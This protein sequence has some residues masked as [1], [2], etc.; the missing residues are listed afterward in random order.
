MRDVKT[1]DIGEVAKQ[2][3]LPTSALRFYEEKGLI[4]S[5]GRHGLRRLFDPNVLERLSLIALARYGG[6]SLKEIAAMF[7]SDG[8]LTVDRGQLLNKAEAL[9]HTIK[10]L[11][12]VRDSL[13]HVANCPAQDH[14]EC[15]KFQQL[16]RLAGISQNKE[17]NKRSEKKQ[18]GKQ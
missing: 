6:F 2:S 10:R 4:K 16:V 15:P 14:L 5:V 7:S 17:G 8:Q 3:G 11:R 13:R 9:D 1:L 18:K 12:A